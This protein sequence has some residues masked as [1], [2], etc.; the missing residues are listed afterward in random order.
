MKTLHGACLILICAMVACAPSPTPTP[1]PPPPTPTPTRL[2]TATPEPVGDYVP[3]DIPRCEGAK[4]LGHALD[5]QWAGVDA[6]GGGSWYYYHCDASPDDLA[7]VF[8]PK[9]TAAPY[10]WG[11]INWVVRP[12]GTLGV[13]FN[14]VQQIWGYLWFLPSDTPATGSYLVFAE[15]GTEPLE[16]PCCK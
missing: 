3:S 6:I 4:S 5:F 8:R 12:E 9:M 14:T 13:Y 11:E 7:A 16:L 10:E 2:P 15:V 1:T